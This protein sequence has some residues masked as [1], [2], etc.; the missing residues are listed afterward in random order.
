MIMVGKK[1]SSPGPGAGFIIVKGSKNKKILALIKHDGT[2][3]LPKGAL[4]KTDSSFLEC[5][6]RECAE[7]CGIKIKDSDLIKSVPSISSGKLI[8]FTATTQQKPK[9]IKNPHTGIWE[10]AGFKWVTT[11][12]FK[13]NTSKFLANAISQFEN[14]IFLF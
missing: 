1:K 5:A 10:H 4:D 14:Y 12:E 11:A 7:E 6:K 9:I 13:A 2:F 8:V 3:D